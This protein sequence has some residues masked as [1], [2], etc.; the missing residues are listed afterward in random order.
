M[1][2]LGSYRKVS[3]Y[4][5]VASPCTVRTLSVEVLASAASIATFASSFAARSFT[6]AS[7]APFGR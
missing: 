7:L 1:D 2:I 4:N 6:F 5:L 3:P